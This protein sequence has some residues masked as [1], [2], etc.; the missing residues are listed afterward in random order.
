M[1]SFPGWALALVHSVLDVVLPAESRCVLGAESSITE[2][3]EGTHSR[4]PT[5][6]CIVCRVPGLPAHALPSLASMRPGTASL[7]E[8][9]DLCDVSSPLTLTLLQ[10]AR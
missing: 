5:R 8:S 10:G 9:F 7:M 2:Q 6:V 4:A 1:P 3:R